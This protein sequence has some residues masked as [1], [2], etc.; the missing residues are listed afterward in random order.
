MKK[1]PKGTSEYQSSWIVEN[2]DSSDNG[3]VSGSES[4]DTNKEMMDHDITMEMTYG[5][6]SDVVLLTYTLTPH[7]KS[8][9]PHIYCSKFYMNEF[10]II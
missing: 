6:A 2:D 5:D 3:D 4:D 7:K 10:Q 8:P 1:V 9:R